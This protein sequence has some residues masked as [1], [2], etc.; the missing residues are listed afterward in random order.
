MFFARGT[1]PDLGAA[2]SSDAARIDL[3]AR[4]GLNF[5][6]FAARHHAADFH[7]TMQHATAAPA[8]RWRAS[9][10]ISNGKGEMSNVQ[11]QG[12][13]RGQ[14]RQDLAGRSESTQ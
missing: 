7:K 6:P 10:G 8:G 3:A 12:F 5:V 1:A 9:A 13:R 2:A 14:R 4:A 11:A